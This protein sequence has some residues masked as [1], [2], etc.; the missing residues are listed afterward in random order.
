MSTQI[1][2]YSIYKSNITAE[3]SMRNQASKEAG[4]TTAYAKYYVLLILICAINSALFA[5]S[6]QFC[7]TQQCLLI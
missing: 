3:L 6:S 5:H 1:V 7:K 4:H 2:S